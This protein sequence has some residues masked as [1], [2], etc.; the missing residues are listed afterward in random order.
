MV[1]HIAMYIIPGQWHVA[2]TVRVVLLGICN[3]ARRRVLITRRIN[4]NEVR[5]ARTQNT[6]AILIDFD[7]LVAFAIC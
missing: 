4:K 3:E 1:S 6:V 7:D 5:S 2:R